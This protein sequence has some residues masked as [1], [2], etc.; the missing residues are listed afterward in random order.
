[1]A[2]PDSEVFSPDV[3][4]TAYAGHDKEVSCY[5]LAEQL[6][7]M[8]QQSTREDLVL[9]QLHMQW[10]EFVLICVIWFTHIKMLCWMCF[11]C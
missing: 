11:L 3:A 7:P 10:R 4:L 5:V 8:A 9:K 1:M 6:Q 2:E